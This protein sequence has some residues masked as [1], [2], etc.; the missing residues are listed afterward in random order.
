MSEIE[1]T[2]YNILHE[3]KRLCAHC[4]SGTHRPHNCPVQQI[5]LRV[6]QLRGVPLVVNS[7]FCGLLWTK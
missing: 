4:S 6:S 1:K 2:K 3:L 5:A 7:E